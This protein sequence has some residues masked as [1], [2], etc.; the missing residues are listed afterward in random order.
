MRKSDFLALR[1]TGGGAFSAP[2]PWQHGAR[3]I[4]SYELIIVTKGVVYLQEGERRFTL[5]E[6]DHLLLHPGVPHSGWKPSTGPT[7]FYWIHFTSESLPAEFAAPCTGRLREPGALIQLARQ[8]LHMAE[9][10]AYPAGTAEA[11]LYVLLAE[12]LVQRAP[13]SP[14]DAFAARIHEY[15][16][17]HSYGP[18]TVQS[19]AAA[20]GYH[21]DHLSR[22]LK[23]YC[24]RTLQQDI[25]NER[26]GR[27]RQLLQ[28]T[29]KTVA[30][31][32][33]ELG[34]EDTNLFEK[35]FRYHQ[36]CSPTQYRA[37]F[38]LIHTNHR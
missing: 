31:V 17:S 9:D 23:A 36:H 15:I 35:F 11:M 10:P 5:G 25:A 19:V 22:V 14:R 2:G 30:Q 4:S 18:L 27:A 12:L 13:R 28:D 37:D 6:G 26:M 1:Y 29:G 8:L 3:I 16:R 32:A 38:S 34:F 7:A 33:L 21:P 20:F 24:G